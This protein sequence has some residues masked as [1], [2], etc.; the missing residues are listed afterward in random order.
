MQAKSRLQTK[1]LCDVVFSFFTDDA[2]FVVLNEIDSIA[3]DLMMC[4]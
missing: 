2:D 1:K 4:G 3:N